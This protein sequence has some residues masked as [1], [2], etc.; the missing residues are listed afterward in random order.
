M[1][2]LIG[3]AKLPRLS[4]CGNLTLDLVTF[5]ITFLLNTV[6]DEIKLWLIENIHLGVIVT[7]AYVEQSK[8][9]QLF[10]HVPNMSGI[11]F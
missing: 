1:V 3:V 2:W 8:P 9:D 10:M 6:Q 4:D 7:G 11:Y 5:S